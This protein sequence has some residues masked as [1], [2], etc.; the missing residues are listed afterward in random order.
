MKISEVI[1]Y[2]GGV[3]DTAR[4]LNISYQAV[5]QWV[6]KG[7]VPEGRQWQLQAITDGALTVDQTAA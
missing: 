7:E 4:A 1:E 2:Y 6:E 5:Q 3:A